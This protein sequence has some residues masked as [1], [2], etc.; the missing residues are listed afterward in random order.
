MENEIRDLRPKSDYKRT[1]R[2]EM[3]LGNWQKEAQGLVLSNIINNFVYAYL[4]S[5]GW[6]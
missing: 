6:M 2:K 1:L 5:E 4:E 3:S